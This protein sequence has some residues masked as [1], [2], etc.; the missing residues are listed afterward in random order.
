MNNHES[1][2]QTAPAIAIIGMAGRFP[3]ADNVN[4]F[5]QNLKSGTDS[6]T[7]FTEDEMVDDGVDIARLRT[8]D[9]H[10]RAGGVLKDGD[11]MDAGFFGIYPKAAALMDP[12][13]RVMLECAWH[14]MEDAGYEPNS[15]P[16][17]IGVYAGQSL[18]TYFTE[19]LLP[20]KYLVEGVDEFQTLVDN[21]PDSLPT[22]VSYKLN[23]KGPSVSVGTACSTS[24][25]AVFQACQSLL[26]YQCD[27]ALAGGVSV[28][29]PQSRGHLFQE[30]GIRSSDGVCRPFD[31]RAEGMVSGNGVGL[32][33]LKRLD[34]AVEDGDSIYAVVRGIA[35]NNDG[36]DKVSFAAPSIN[37]Q[38]EVISMAMAQ[39]GVNP[40]DISY[41]EA[42][43]TATPLGD[44]IEMAG[45][46][47]AFRAGTDRKGYCAITS[48]KSN[49]GHLDAAA[50]ITSLIKAA[51]ALHH[52]TLP[53]TIHF[54]TPNP[55]LDLEN[56]PFY[57][58][59]ELREWETDGRPRIAGVS[60]FGV[61]GTNAHAILEEAPTGES[62]DTGTPG[63]Q[64]LPVSARSEQAIGQAASGLAD[65]ISG[66]PGLNLDD[67][68]FTMQVGRG[69]FPRRGFVVADS[70]EEAARALESITDKSISARKNAP[71]IVF[72]FPGQGSQ[73]V[74]MG[75]DLYK[76]YSVFR[77]VVDSC[78]SILEPKLGFDIRD[79]IYPASSEMEEESARQLRETWITQPA[80]FIVE[81]AMARLWMDWGVEPTRMIGHS[82]GEY[83]AACLAGV[84][85]LEDCLGL[86]V[87]RGRFMRD[88][89]GGSMMAVP[90]GEDDL[91]PMLTKDVAIGAINSPTNCV[92]AG[93]QEALA[94]FEEKLKEQDILCRWL[95]TSHAFH[96][97]MMDPM[98]EP[99]EAEF[100]GIQLNTPG[101][102]IISSPTGKELTDEEAL[103]PRYWAS[104]AREAVRF[105]DGRQVLA[106]N[107]EFILLEVGPGN[108]LASLA[109]LGSPNGSDQMILSSLGHALNEPDDVRNILEAVGQLWSEGVSINFHAL[110]EDGQPR[111]VSLPGYPFERK[112][113][114]IDAPKTLPHVTGATPSAAVDMPSVP[115]E[116]SQNNAS[117]VT[118]QV[119]R[120]LD[121]DA[122]T[123]AERMIRQQLALMNSQ[124]AILSQV[125]RPTVSSI[126]GNGSDHANS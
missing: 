6:I 40:D 15:Y 119:V 56:S 53:P 89:P 77:N 41:V 8:K 92:V 35:V 98:L 21:E 71:E 3:G 101:L 1:T 14:A 79:V 123:L 16:G 24:L 17:L 110:H 50:G 57:I 75:R 81:Y 61:G 69:E 2:E 104:H 30:G 107:S 44:P 67:V 33:V 49:V 12:Q 94:A 78:A 88:L 29:V 118:T 5:W 9:N 43:G 108:T 36:S 76:K 60:S 27:M 68:A 87:S 109:R 20:N 106:E 46:T 73:Y 113:H 23:L 59:D 25:V 72:M 100:A 93:P 13:G 11:K 64:L 99:F 112:R 74:N 70:S 4:E 55:N 80:M 125:G 62:R 91:I 122:T 51:L 97:P 37:G 48:V 96:S 7:H 52:K 117:S 95:H 45:L 38:T 124:L 114:W 22:R 18:N 126:N 31:A 26:T 54:D 102:S 65:H 32:V 90:L 120:K 103:D 83:T 39:A 116:M 10:V 85:S 42:H 111:R 105:S 84:F 115:A 28:R 63:L 47:N 19:N 66:S 121:G 82:I 86:L 34:E 58:L